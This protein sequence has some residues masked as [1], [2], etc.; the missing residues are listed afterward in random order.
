MPIQGLPH[1]VT[2]SSQYSSGSS[3]Q[4]KS[5]EFAPN[6]CKNFKAFIIPKFG[7]I[8]DSR[9]AQRHPARAFRGRPV[10]VLGWV[11]NTRV[12][13]Q[14][15]LL[16]APSANRV[17]NSVEGALASECMPACRIKGLFYLLPLDEYLAYGCIRPHTNRKGYIIVTNTHCFNFAPSTDVQYAVI[18]TI[19][20]GVAL[21]Y[22]TM[23]V[24][25]SL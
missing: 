22:D 16:A 25:A 23:A 24:R 9:E 7:S 1:W 4:N 14:N 12:V 11:Y 3:A 15:E 17:H 6:L 10:T 2:S 18:H 20:A 8:V 21:P 5:I 19:V 13:V